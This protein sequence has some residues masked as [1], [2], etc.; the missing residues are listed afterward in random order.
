VL[1]AFGCNLIAV[2]GNYVLP[3]PQHAPIDKLFSTAAMRGCCLSL[4]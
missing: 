1:T 3:F 2:V 4:G